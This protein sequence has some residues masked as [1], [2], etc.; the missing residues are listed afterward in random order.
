MNKAINIEYDKK[1]K[2][3]CSWNGGE[4]V[5]IHTRETLYGEY[6]ETLFDEELVDYFS[7]I[8]PCG[9]DRY[10]TIEEYLNDCVDCDGDLINIEF[11]CD[12]MSIIQIM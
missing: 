8:H 7:S 4:T 11:K 5:Q 10:E 2:W 9:T 6:K 1:S 12:N 3:L